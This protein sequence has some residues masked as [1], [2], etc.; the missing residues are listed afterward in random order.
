[1]QEPCTED[2]DLGLGLGL[3]LGLR[4][5]LGS[6]SGSGSGLGLR[7]V[8]LHA[9]AISV[10]VT[11]HAES[12]SFAAHPSMTLASCARLTSLVSKLSSGPISAVMWSK[13]LAGGLIV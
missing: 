2:L 7:L 13:G 3:G 1:M 10:R 8:A 5:R 9:P 4:L 11:R 12:A 6:G